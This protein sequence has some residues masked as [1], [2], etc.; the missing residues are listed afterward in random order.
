MLKLE[1]T[2]NKHFVIEEFNKNE[3]IHN[4]EID[5]KGNINR[6]LIIKQIEPLILYE[7]N[8]STLKK[9]IN[10]RIIKIYVSEDG[11]YFQFINNMTPF[12]PLHKVV[13]FIA[14]KIYWFV[15]EKI[16]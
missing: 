8:L 14:N 13:S 5:K 16:I 3:F 10:K 2:K 6:E 11:K 9:F 4:D 12:T 15:K 7:F 1:M